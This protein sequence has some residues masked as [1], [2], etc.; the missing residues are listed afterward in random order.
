MALDLDPQELTSGPAHRV[1]TSLVAPRP[2]GWISTVS[3]DGERD[4]L[5]PY[6]YFNAVSTSPP[7][8]CFSAGSLTD[9]QPKDSA[10]F[11]IETG[12]FVANLVTESLAAEMNRSSAPIEGSEFEYAGLEREDSAVVE[13]PRV[14]AADAHLECTVR[15]TLE[16][17][18]NTVV[19][20]DV[21]HVHVDEALLDEDGAVDAA[22]VPA[23]GRLGGPYYTRVDRLDLTRSGFGAWD[24][25]PP[26]GFRVH[27]ETNELRP[28]PDDLRAIREALSRFVQGDAPE[29]AAAEVPVDPAELEAIAADERRRARYLDGITDDERIHAALVEAGVDATLSYR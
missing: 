16:I 20:G 25:E 12:A 10:R 11:A 3:P 9:G 22:Q 24:G 14:A 28:I 6:S 5:A 15:E 1:L 4:N 19:F 8:V 18:S 26:A 29:T 7:V 21:V 27:P 23:V 13:P 2:I 17:G